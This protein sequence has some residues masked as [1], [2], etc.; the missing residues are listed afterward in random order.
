[1]RPLSAARLLDAWE[2][3]L[4]QAPVQRA[5]TLLA[6]AQP[7]V[8]WDELAEQPIGQRDRGLLA[9]REMLFGSRLTLV[10]RCPACD[11]AV[12]CGL[13]T[14]EFLD[15]DEPEPRQWPCTA[16]ID[17]YRIQYRLPVSRD[18]LALPAT[19]EPDTLRRLLLARC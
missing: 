5:L 18:L 12:E 7:G 11:A 3:G 14:R 15:R 9:L 4:A 13:S 2:R 17:G 16:E 1:M 19:E 10:A 8:A 6:A